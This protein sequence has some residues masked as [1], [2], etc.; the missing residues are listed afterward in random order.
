MYKSPSEMPRNPMMITIGKFAVTPMAEGLRCAG[1]VELGGIKL[2]PSKA[3]IRLIRRRVSEVFPNLTYEN[4]EEWM[5]FRP[6]TPD[7]LPLIGEIA[8]SGI[9]TAFGHQHVG[10]TAGAKTG[11]LISDIV[12]KRMPNI[13]MS[14]YDPN[15]YAAH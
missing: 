14:P 13:D 1:T 3:P 15:R 12:S 7:S 8:Q 11:R 9:Y 4:R 10:L 5:G 6:S 2:G